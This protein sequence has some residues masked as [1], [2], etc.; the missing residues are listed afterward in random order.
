MK[1]L[2][3]SILGIGFVLSLLQGQGAPVTLNPFPPNSVATTVFTYSGTYPIYQ[4]ITKPN[5]PWND[6]RVP[7]SFSWTRTASTLT[8]IA[9]ATNVG[10]VTTSTAHGLRVGNPVVVTGATVDTDLNATYVI[11]TVP[12]TTTFTIT[13][14]AVADATYNESTLVL[15]T[16]AP[17]TTVA[18]WSIMKYLYDGSNNLISTAWAN[19]TSTANQ[20][21]SSASTL[22][23]R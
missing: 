4:C 19:G 7:A 10:T 18:I 12:S 1:T 6:G 13:T 5:G 16:S 23:Y 20:I 17:R 14:A 11:A 3:L 2:L 15:F 9:V 8:S 22:S 21:C